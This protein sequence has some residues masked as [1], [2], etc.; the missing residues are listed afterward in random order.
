MMCLK[1]VVLF[2]MGGFRV[3]GNVIKLYWMLSVLV[4][5]FFLIMFWVISGIVIIKYL[6]KNL[7]ISVYV[8][9]L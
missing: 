2:K 9:K 7:V 6:L 1:C 3:K 8:S 5:S 4:I